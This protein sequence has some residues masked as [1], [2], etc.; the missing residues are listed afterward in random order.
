MNLGEW[1]LNDTVKPRVEFK[2][3][4]TLT[5]PTTVTLYITDPSG[6]VSTYTYGAAEITKE[7]TG[8]FYKNIAVAEQG[9][10]HARYVGTGACAAQA[11]M[12]WTVRRNGA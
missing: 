3:G 1:D 10:W 6:D 8:I 9:F 4:D 7:G 5:D 12:Y 2:V 11:Q